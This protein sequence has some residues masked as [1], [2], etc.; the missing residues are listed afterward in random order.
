MMSYDDK[1]LKYLRSKFPDTDEKA[2]Y[3][4]YT[5]HVH[6]HVVDSANVYM[7]AEVEKTCASCNGQCPLGN[8]TMKP[9]AVVKRSNAGFEYLSVGW[10]SDMACKFRPVNA[11]MFAQSGL[12]GSQSAKTFE[13]YEVNDPESKNAKVQAMKAAM[14]RTNLILAG[15][16]GTGKTHLAVAIAIDA[17]KH[18]RQAYFRLV[19]DLLEELRQSVRDEEFHE[20]MTRFKNVDVLV[21]DD[22]GKERSTQAGLDYL[23]QIIDYRYRNNLQTVI[24]TNAKTIQELEKWGAPEYLTPMCSRM[25]ENGAW[26]SLIN[27]QDRRLKS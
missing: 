22:L 1:A 5:G 19:N 18:N 7:A 2:F 13:S 8:P 17:M 12:T 20:V 6:P 27:V 10:V 9:V 24:T 21:L 4:D 3:T 26:V 25:L 15:K 16:R 11:R 14:T 23:Y